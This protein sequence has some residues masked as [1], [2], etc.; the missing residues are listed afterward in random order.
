[1]SMIIS[2]HKIT[3]TPSQGG[4]VTVSNNTQQYYGRDQ[5]ACLQEYASGRAFCESCLPLKNPI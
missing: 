1:M 2:S 4:V 3:N 5:N